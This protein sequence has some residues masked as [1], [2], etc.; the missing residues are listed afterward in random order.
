M[1]KDYFIDGFLDA[2]EINKKV[3]NVYTDGRT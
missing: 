3:M 2:Q 1:A